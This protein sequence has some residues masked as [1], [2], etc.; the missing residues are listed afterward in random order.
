MP[1][2]VFL[3]VGPGRGLRRRL[4][5]QAV[6]VGGQEGADLGAAG[7]EL[8]FGGFGAS[9]WSR[10]LVAAPVSRRAIRSVAAR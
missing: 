3:L 1:S 6:G 8:G 9:G 5:V 4:G 10:Q 7:R 2:T